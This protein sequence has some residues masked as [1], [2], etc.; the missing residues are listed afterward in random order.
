M[1]DNWTTVEWVVFEYLG[2]R[3]M[4]MSFLKPSSM[5]G[6]EGCLDTSRE[7]ARLIAKMDKKAKIDSSL[8]APTNNNAKA[9][10]AI[11][12]EMAAQTKM[13][14]RRII[15]LFETPEDRA[16]MLIEIKKDLTPAATI[17]NDDEVDMM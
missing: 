3:G 9:R 16:Q 15:M 10:A 11:A 17:D 6:D 12:E 2:P 13:A 4:G 7:G 1:A 8:R 14:N 5:D